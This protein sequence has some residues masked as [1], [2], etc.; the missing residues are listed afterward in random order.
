MVTRGQR[1]VRA[2]AKEGKPN[3]FK[4]TKKIKKDKKGGQTRSSKTLPRADYKKFTRNELT[5]KFEKQESDMN[6]RI[7][8]ALAMEAETQ[9]QKQKRRKVMNAVQSTKNRITLDLNIE[10]FLA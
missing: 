6:D 9:A 7:Q 10:A 8:E 1:R 5:A 3:Y 2:E 4:V